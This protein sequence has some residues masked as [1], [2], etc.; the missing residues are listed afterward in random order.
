MLTRV[1]RKEKLG[2]ELS[3]AQRLEAIGQVMESLA[4]DLNNLLTVIVG[5]A[6]LLEEGLSRNPDLLTL[7]ELTRNAALR[8]AE[9]TNRLLAFSC[10]QNLELRPIEINE[11]VM[12]VGD[13][14][15]RKVSADVEI[16]K[17]LGAGLWQA[18]VDAPRLEC[19]LLDVAANACDAMP[20]G[21]KLT[22]KTSNFEL[23]QSQAGNYSEIPPG[24]YILIAVSDSGIGMDEHTR[25]H[26]FDPFFTTK[27]AGKGKGLGLSAVYGFVKQ[28]GGLIQI[29][30]ERRLGTTVKI[31]LPISDK[32]G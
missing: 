17:V 32:S 10:Q 9:I 4:H 30:S 7:A 20:D 6:E 27:N 23:D 28:S 13:R 21:G 2:S 14:L 22:F 31:Y 29:H 15:R 3:P 12:R 11:L 1:P 24:Q 19:A 5:N 18:L 8:G 25:A 26:A 16:R